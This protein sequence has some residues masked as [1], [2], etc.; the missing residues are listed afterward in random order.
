MNYNGIPIHVSP[1]ATQRVCKV[2]P[3]PIKK[4]RKGY[5]VVAHQQPGCYRIGVGANAQFVMHP[6]LYEQLRKETS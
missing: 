5:R 1:H 4:R 6:V 3:S 2:I